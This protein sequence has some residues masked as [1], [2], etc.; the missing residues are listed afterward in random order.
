MRGLED[1][2]EEEMAPTPLAQSV[3]NPP[4]MQ[5]AWGQSLGE[6][7][8]LEKEMA[9]QSVFLPGE[10]HVQR[11]LAGYSPWSRKSRTRLSD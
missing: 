7:D 1:G 11:R 4:T 3:K 9:T 10:L 8:P 5:E 2:L 6:E